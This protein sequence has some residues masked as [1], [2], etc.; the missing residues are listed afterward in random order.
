MKRPARE[1]VIRY[2]VTCG[3]ALAIGILELV[4]QLW[5][6]GSFFE[7]T[8]WE[9]MRLL[10]DAFTVPGMLLVLVGL[11]ML[12]VKQGAMDGLSYIGHYL[13]HAFVPWKRTDAQKYGDFI[14]AKEEKRQQQDRHYGH[15]LVV[16]GVCIA[17]SFL[18]LW[19]YYQY[20]TV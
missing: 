7:L 1:T 4:L 17:I 12:L 19:L 13:V 9:Q 16:G 10:C 6:A 5:G 2:A 15:L 18:F 14:T 3:V 8:R 20:Y 11:L